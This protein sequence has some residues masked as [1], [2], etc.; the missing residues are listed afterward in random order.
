MEMGVFAVGVDLS[1]QFGE[2]AVDCAHQVLRADDLAD[3]K[4]LVHFVLDI[5]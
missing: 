4:E 2:L 5:F 3:D 1:R